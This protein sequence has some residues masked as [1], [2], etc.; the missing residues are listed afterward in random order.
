MLHPHGLETLHGCAQILCT[1][2]LCIQ[3]SESAIVTDRQSKNCTSK[4]IATRWSSNAEVV[5][6]SVTLI[7]KTKPILA[8]VVTPTSTFPVRSTDSV[9][10]SFSSARWS[11]RSRT[12]TPG[13]SAGRWGALSFVVLPPSFVVLSVHFV[14]RAPCL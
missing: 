1:H 12:C 7:A 10:S 4:S 5:S 8:E 11:G 9:G 6:G 3:S 2:E 13:S 14:A